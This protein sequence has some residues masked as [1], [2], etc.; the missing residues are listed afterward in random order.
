MSVINIQSRDLPNRDLREP[1]DT[2]I[3]CVLPADHR[4]ANDINDRLICRSSDILDSVET[5]T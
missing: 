2:Q 5:A 3:L 4:N 1:K